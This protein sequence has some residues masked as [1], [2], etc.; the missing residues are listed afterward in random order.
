MYASPEVA[1][2]NYIYNNKL[3]KK[4]SELQNW[5]RKNPGGK[6]D[7]PFERQYT[8]TGQARQSHQ[9]TDCIY[10]NHTDRL[11]KNCNNNDF[12][13]F[14]FKLENFNDLNFYYNEISKTIT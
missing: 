9:H 2:C 4:E 12:T 11:R 1:R 3:L 5:K 14:Y 6:I 7:L 10:G 13:S 8:S